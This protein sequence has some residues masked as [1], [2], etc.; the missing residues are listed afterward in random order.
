[1]ALIAIPVKW[2]N[3]SICVERGH[4][5]T[6]IDEAVLWG[7]YK[8]PRSI[9]AL[10]SAA[11]LNRRIIVTTLTRLMRYRL[12]EIEVRDSEAV[13]RVTPFGIASINSPSGLPTFP[14]EYWPRI[15][16]SVELLHGSCFR[17]RELKLYTRTGLKRLRAS[18]NSLITINIPEHSVQFDSEANLARIADLANLGPDEHIKTVDTRSAQLQDRYMVVSGAKHDFSHLPKTAPA[19]LIDQLSDLASKKKTTGSVTV[20][21]SYVPPRRSTEHRY[22]SCAFDLSDLTIGGSSQRKLLERVLSDAKSTVIIQSTFIKVDQVKQ[23]FEAFR[24][25]CRRGVNITLLWGGEKD[26]KT[27][28]R[29]SNAVRTL[30]NLI[31]N[32]PD[33]RGKVRIHPRSLNTH[34]KVLVSDTQDGQWIAAVGSCNWLSSP[35]QATDMTVT[36]RD[37]RSVADILSAVRSLVDQDGEID[38]LATQLTLVVRKLRASRTTSE[39]NAK[40]RILS[41][42]EHDALARKASGSPKGR[43]VMSSHRVGATARTGALLPSMKAASAEDVDPVFLFYTQSG[44][45]KKPHLRELIQDAE[46]NGIDV[47]KTR[48]IPLHAKFLLWGSDDLIVTSLNW[49]SSA[50]GA[51]DPPGELGVHIHQS[52]ISDFIMKQLERFVPELAS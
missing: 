48:K 37:A 13:F 4:S 19:E 44:P 39:S 16:V 34:A 1:M 9:S 50:S 5:W 29:N 11:N 47:I 2:V 38:R 22:E 51:I 24:A 49:A 32:E 46:S 31:R 26:Q 25:A 3:C 17:S 27:K 6:V 41:G 14:Q 33:M 43:F 12:V 36:L 21:S 8:E 30:E 28:D 18:S 10:C 45:I 40:I 42:E 20:P 23:L 35:M 7:L 52:G 15:S